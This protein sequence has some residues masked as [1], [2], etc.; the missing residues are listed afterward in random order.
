MLFPFSDIDTQTEKFLNNRGKQTVST[1]SRC[2]IPDSG[3]HY[4]YITRNVSR[5][6]PVTRTQGQTWRRFQKENRRQSQDAETLN[7]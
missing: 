4:R 7:L 3:L 2:K 5:T 6:G 1:H